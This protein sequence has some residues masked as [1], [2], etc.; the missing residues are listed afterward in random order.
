MFS[1]YD[2]NEML[3]VDTYFVKSILFEKHKNM[4]LLK[5]I[6]NLFILRKPIFSSLY[7]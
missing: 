1:S 7:V 3:K 5:N 2:R 6:V 4:I